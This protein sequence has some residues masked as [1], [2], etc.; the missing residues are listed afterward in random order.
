MASEQCPVLSY[1]S[2]STT[3]QIFSGADEVELAPNGEGVDFM[4]LRPNMARCR[5]QRPVLPG[6]G[7]VRITCGKRSISSGLL[8]IPQI[9]EKG[10]E[11]QKEWASLAF[12]KYQRKEAKTKRYTPR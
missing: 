1:K 11:D 6:I 2:Q 12:D 3:D 7:G 4:R 10:G 5:A 9:P 8:F